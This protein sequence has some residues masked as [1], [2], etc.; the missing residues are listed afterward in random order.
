MRTV[1]WVISLLTLVPRVAPYPGSI[2]LESRVVR[3]TQ[4]SKSTNGQEAVE[5]PL[6]DWIGNTDLQVI[7]DI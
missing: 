4:T 6:T 5:V 2:K 7:P 3:R 1:A